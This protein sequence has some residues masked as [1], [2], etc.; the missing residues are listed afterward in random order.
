MIP[1]CLCSYGCRSETE[2][3]RVLKRKWVVEWEVKLKTST[4]IK[5]WFL[6]MW[7]NISRW[8]TELLNFTVRTDFE[9][10]LSTALWSKRQIIMVI[11]KV[12]FIT[13]TERTKPIWVNWKI[14]FQF[15][16]KIPDMSLK[17][18]WICAF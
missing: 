7:I 10:H 6:N 5:Y 15:K 2:T 8:D 9:D 17:W 3:L 16:V 14:S 18:H 12:N 1:Y 13:G 4:R 11:T